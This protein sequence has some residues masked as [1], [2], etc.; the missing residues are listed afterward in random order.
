MGQLVVELPASLHVSLTKAFGE[1]QKFGFDECAIKVLMLQG[2]PDAIE[3]LLTKTLKSP[4]RPLWY[5]A[6]ISGARPTVD[7][8]NPMNSAQR[9]PKTQ[10]PPEDS[11]VAAPVADK[12][13]PFSNFYKVLPY[14]RV[15][16]LDAS[17]AGTLVA[18]AQAA[19]RVKV[20]QASTVTTPVSQPCDVDMSTT[21]A[22]IP[23]PQRLPDGSFARPV[24]EGILMQFAPIRSTPRNISLGFRVTFNDVGHLKKILWKPEPSATPIELKIPEQVTTSRFISMADLTPTQTLLLAGLTA[25]NKG[26]QESTVLLVKASRQI[27][28]ETVMRDRIAQP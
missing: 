25:S 23:T 13:P 6:S 15:G 10:S 5:A 26:K 11:E 7:L 22:F 1:S 27:M 2:P 24:K 20:E 12:V 19:T 28:G 14:Y 21:V 18:G 3:E 4:L 16:L 9:S 8:P 17:E